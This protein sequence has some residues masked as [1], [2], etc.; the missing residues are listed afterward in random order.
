MG[1]YYARVLHSLGE[2][3]R[4]TD[5]FINYIGLVGELAPTDRKR[6]SRTFRFS[7]WDDLACECYHTIGLNY[8]Y[9]GD[10]DQALRYYRKA[11]NTGSRIRRSELSELIAAPVSELDVAVRRI[12]VLLARSRFHEGALSAGKALASI[13]PEERR[14]TPSR[15]SVLHVL[16]GECLMGQGDWAGAAKALGAAERRSLSGDRTTLARY[17]LLSARLAVASSRGGDAERNLR[18]IAS[19]DA[20]R[21]PTPYQRQFRVLQRRVYGEVRHRR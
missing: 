21:I 12:E 6:V 16:L 20:R 5:R 10:R 4:S 13:A 3:D 18:R 11:Q 14:E 15:W 7:D 19:M 9:L 17:H 1:Y 2:Y 8:E